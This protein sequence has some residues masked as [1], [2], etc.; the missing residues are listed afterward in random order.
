M[1]ASCSSSGEEKEAYAIKF[2]NTDRIKATIDKTLQPSK[3][4]ADQFKAEVLEHK[5]DL[6]TIEGT[7]PS[8][9]F[10]NDN[11][12][13]TD[14]NPS[15][16]K[17]E[18]SAKVTVDK[19]NTNGEPIEKT[20]TLTGLGYE[21]VDLT[22]LV[23]TIA[24]KENNTDPQ[25]IE[26][27]DQ[28]N[29]STDTINAEKL[30][31]LVLVDAT[32][33]KI[34]EVSGDN[35]N[36]I[37]NEILANQIL[38][39]SDLKTDKTEG[40]VTFKLSVEKPKNGAGDTLEKTIIFTGFKKETDSTPATNYQIAFQDGDSEGKYV[41]TTVADKTTEDFSDTDTI[42]TLIISEKEVIF[43]P[44]KGELP[45]DDNWWNDN[46]QITNTPTADPAKGEITVR[47]QLNN[48]DSS[49]DSQNINKEIILKGFLPK[50]TIPATGETTTPKTE[51]STVTLGLNGSLTELQS[52]VNG[53][54]VIQKKAILF[55]K[56]FE[57]IN[58]AAS[59][60]GFKYEPVTGN[61]GAFTLKFTLA[62]NKYYGDDKNLGT[63]P[64]EFSILIKG[65]SATATNGTELRNKSA[66]TDSN[67]LS[68][69]LVDPAL[70][71]KTYD[72]Y[73]NESATFFTKSFIFKYRKHLL[74]GDFTK[75]DEAGEEGFLSRYSADKFVTIVTNDTAET[76]QIKFKILK[77]KLTPAPSADKEYSI[78]FNG[79]KPTSN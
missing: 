60:T 44:A 28:A 15:D 35:A 18:V 33:E 71:E 53:D 40:K 76:I 52:E 16:D 25:E 41:L 55:E 4:T 43:K 30:M 17:K 49:D 42:K 32:K 63:T 13:I 14:L 6:F 57:P 68:I 79:F 19:A 78:V 58:D 47:I 67:P 27:S 64:K 72:E 66:A 22:K 51:V 34:L 59:I 73:K 8:D 39:V 77:D 45:S 37:T 69:A 20:I 65:I 11:I 61:N 38:K 7:L 12:K 54:W 1:V 50:E 26:L 46:L 62:E 3:L 31:E 2:T 21:E 36:Q 24:L 75:V 74:T 70:G 29:N 56:G 23:Y 5:S 10:L 48:S 9:S